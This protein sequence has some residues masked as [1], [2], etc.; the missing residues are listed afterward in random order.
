MED[1]T[2][3]YY[4][5]NWKYKGTRILSA[6]KTLVFDE[7]D[8]VINENVHLT[9]K[10]DSKVVKTRLISSSGHFFS[11][12]LLLNSDRSLNPFFIKNATEEIMFCGEQIGATIDLHYWQV[13]V[14]RV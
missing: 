9:M 2:L 7:I 10:L 6:D 12:Y 4:K 5:G 8:L 11:D 3:D 1:H 14:S 13:K